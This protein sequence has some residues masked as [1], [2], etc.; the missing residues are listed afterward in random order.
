MNTS[1]RPIP[2][3]TMFLLVLTCVLVPAA[4]A[5]EAPPLKASELA[6][7]IGR[8][9]E[10]GGYFWNDNYVSNEASYLHPL[11]KLRE[12]GIHGGV[13]LGV[14]P[15]Q[16]LSYIAS[17]RPRY[18]FIVDIRRQNMLEH[19]LFKALF[20][21]ARDRRDYLSLLLSRPVRGD[22]ARR[23]R[24]GVEELVSYF[25][26][27]EADP[28]LF[29]RT[30]RRVREF[31]TRGTRLRLS[32]QDFATI[33]KVHRA[34][35]QRGLAIKY[36]YVPVPTLGEL[37]MERDLQGRRRNFLNNDADYRYLK[38][39]HEQNRII[40]VVGDFAGPH[41][42]KE[43]GRYLRERG[44]S[45][46][47]FYTSNVEQYLLRSQNWQSFV[48]NAK[49]LPLDDRA[50]FI[51]SYWSSRTRHPESEPGYRSTQVIQYIRP[52]LEKVDPFKQPTYLELVTTETIK[53]R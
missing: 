52:F 13:Y 3:R 42:L 17:L 50:L 27:A 48:R 23:E 36:D 20:H 11:G 21:L 2:R 22:I 8:L 49:T 26:Q 6:N 41:S 37:L 30:Q 53:L 43:L 4:M 38:Q 18:S 25:R 45:V 34:F 16:N 44:E 5:A 46:S 24:Y 9:S 15:D 28:D 39:L 33:E 19:F 40:P 7:L 29:D 10:E 1:P 32:D 31:L 51:R 47:V 35:Y 14:G 12:L